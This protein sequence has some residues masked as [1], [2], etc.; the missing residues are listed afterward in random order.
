VHDGVTA[1]DGGAQGFYV[2]QVA[3]YGFGR[4]AGQVFQFAGGADEKA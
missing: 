4:E 3:D 2:E 1:V